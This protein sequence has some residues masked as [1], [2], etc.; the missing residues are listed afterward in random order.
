M[1]YI[2]KGKLCGYLCSD[3]SESL[4]NIKVILYR[5]ARTQD[6]ALLA[7]ANAKETFHQ[8]T[9]QELKEKSKLV[10]AETMTDEAGNFTFSLS[11]KDK[12]EGGAF[13]IDFVCGTGWGKPTPPKKKTDFQFHITTIQPQWREKES[14]QQVINYFAW[15]YCIAQRYWCHILRLIDRWVIHGKVTD[16]ETGKPVS[17]VRV[18]AYDVDLIQDDPLGND[19]TNALGHFKIVYTS[20][21]F[22]KTIFSWLNIEWPAGPDLYF[23]IESAAGVALLEEPRSTGHRSDRTNVS[24]CFCVKFCVKGA[25]VDKSWFTHIGNY[26]I[27]SDIDSAG[28][29]VVNKSFATGVGFG[30]F[31]ATKLVGYATKRVP[32]DLS[33][34]LYYRFMYSLDGTTYNP[35][36]EPNVYAARL[37]VGVREIIWNGVTAFQ[38]IVIDPTK[39]ASVADSIPPDGFPAPVPDHVLRLDPAGWVRVDQA[40]LDNG[41]YGPLMWLN[42]NTLVPGG[43]TGAGDTVGNNP[44]SPKNGQKVLIAFQTTDD[45]SNLASPH[46][47]EQVLK[48]AM[49]VNNWNEVSLLELTELVV[50]GVGCNPVTTNAHVKFTADHEL[51]ATWALSVS[52]AAI[53]GGITINAAGTSGNVP[54]GNATTIDFANPVNTVTPAFST[55][56][57]CAYRLGL[58]TRRKLTDGESND[59]ARTNEI[60]F[61]R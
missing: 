59:W 40:G 22:S 33:K 3:Y 48:A 31:G 21:E 20:V 29:T 61:C 19:F 10:I 15:E 32:T 57:S 58:T 52:S 12:Y 55:W 27:A 60:I 7:V 9:D 24:N 1:N 56:P 45:P 28:L 16:C 35:V 17:G 8:V 14:E 34:V 36:T 49:H 41:F 53:P 43:A 42:T 38:D 6:T 46:F 30:F 25:V 44:A 54:R 50:G 37:K 13:D 4:G 26:I 5:V 47:N 18:F 2:F 39:P 51:I 11:E 23:R